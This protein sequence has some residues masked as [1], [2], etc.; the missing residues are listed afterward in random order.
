M[1]LFDAETKFRLLSPLPQEYW[2]ARPMRTRKIQNT[3]PR[4][5]LERFDLYSMHYGAQNVL[6]DKIPANPPMKWDDVLTS[7]VDKPKESLRLSETNEKM[8][9][10]KYQRSP[11]FL[12]LGNVTEW[13]EAA[14]ANRLRGEKNEALN[15][16]WCLKNTSCLKVKSLRIPW[17][18]C[19]LER[20]V[21]RIGYITKR[22]FYLLILMTTSSMFL[23]GW[24]FIEG[25][26]VFITQ[27]I[28]HELQESFFAPN[29]VPDKEIT[30]KHFPLIS[31]KGLLGIRSM[32]KESLR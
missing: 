32:K 16:K 3:K 31:N 7:L 18:L 29:P 4:R 10:Y 8:A 11:W 21:C 28:A 13:V 1:N 15:T 9:Y 2:P 26:I 14:E 30:K 23:D 20:G 22:V 25:H 27:R 24:L 17:R 5:G 19:M 6:D 12:N